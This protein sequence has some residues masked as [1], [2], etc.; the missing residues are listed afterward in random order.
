MK[1]NVFGLEIS[2]S[3]VKENIDTLG[4]LYEVEP[5]KHATGYTSKVWSQEEVDKL[6]DMNSRDLTIVGMARM[7]GRT[8]NAIHNKLW[9]LKKSGVIS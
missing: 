4:K 5:K 8:T 6:I 9:K 2:F 1:F 3:K 7:I